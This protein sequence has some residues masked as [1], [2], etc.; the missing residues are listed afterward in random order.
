MRLFVGFCAVFPEDRSNVPEHLIGSV[1]Q[2]LNEI[3]KQISTGK[4]RQK[5]D[6]QD[7]LLKNERFQKRQ[8]ADPQSPEIQKA[9]KEGQ[10]HRVFPC[11]HPSQY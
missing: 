7:A 10:H 2:I 8:R 9:K 1:K 6:K 4:L 5:A 3:L 11:G